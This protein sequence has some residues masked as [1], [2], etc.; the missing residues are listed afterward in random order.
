MELGHALRWRRGVAVRGGQAGQGAR[1]PRQ[2][3]PDRAAYSVACGQDQVGPFFEARSAAAHGASVPAPARPPQGTG[4]RLGADRRAGIGAR[5]GRALARRLPVDLDHEKALVPEIRQWLAFAVQKL[6]EIVALK[7]GLGGDAIAP[8]LVASREAS[9]SRTCS[10]R[11]R[12]DA[13]RR[14]LDTLSERDIRRPS[15][16]AIRIRK[17]RARLKLPLL[18]TT[19]IGSFP[20]TPEIRKARAAFKKGALAPDAYLEAMRAE[21]R[22]AVARQEALGLDVLVHGE[23]ERRDMVEYFGEQLQGF[24]FTENGWVQSYG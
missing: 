1:P 10:E 13:V 5:S 22:Q 8:A 16:F 9:A 19:T 2:G 12:S 4:S 23:A 24:A 7:R 15:P 20:Q 3:G 21:I 6:D 14:Q 11:A 17:Q 18:P